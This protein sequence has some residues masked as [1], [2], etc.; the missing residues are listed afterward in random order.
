MLVCDE[1]RYLILVKWNR[2]LTS[3]WTWEWGV[4]SCENLE[5]VTSLLFRKDALPYRRGTS[6]YL[7]EGLGE[8]A[9]RVTRALD[10]D[11]VRVN[12]I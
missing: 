8:S 4:S 6:R 10:P 2:K 7:G 1:V 5:L 9:P 12:D 11:A 3:G